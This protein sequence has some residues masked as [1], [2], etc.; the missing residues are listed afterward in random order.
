M[1]E[2]I[3]CA[4]VC[5]EMQV[6]SSSRV[7][8]GTSSSHTTPSRGAPVMQRQRF[9]VL[10][11]SWCAAARGAAGA[12]SSALEVACE[13]QPVCPGTGCDCHSASSATA[14]GRQASTLRCTALKRITFYHCD[15]RMLKTDSPNLSHPLALTACD[16]CALYAQLCCS[17]TRAWLT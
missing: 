11:C 17:A 4:V 15:C 9:L 1:H 12:H 7:G 6:C 14:L 8:L 5:R 16:A 13:G 3:L 2:V 10:S